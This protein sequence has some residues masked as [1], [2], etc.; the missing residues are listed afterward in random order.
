MKCNWCRA[1]LTPTQGH[2]ILYYTKDCG[3]FYSIY[4]EKAGKERARKGQYGAYTIVINRSIS[5][6]QA[7]HESRDNA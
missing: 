4:T 7:Y 5:P 1:E 6:P 2:E 3:A